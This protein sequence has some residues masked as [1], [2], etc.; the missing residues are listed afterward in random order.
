MKFELALLEGYIILFT[1]LRMR[2]WVIL[3]VYR[4]V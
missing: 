4:A 1:Y 2:D 3:S